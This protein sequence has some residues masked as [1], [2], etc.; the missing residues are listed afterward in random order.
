L[1]ENVSEYVQQALPLPKDFV[2][3]EE[4]YPTMTMEIKS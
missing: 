4:K 2:D 1:E 3:N